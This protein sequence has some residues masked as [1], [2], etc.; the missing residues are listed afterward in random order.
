MEQGFY[1]QI[2]DQGH[3]SI[4]FHWT[5]ELRHHLQ[6]IHGIKWKGAKRQI[7]EFM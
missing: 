4:I 3:F 1:C 6:G 2:M 7:E 5:E